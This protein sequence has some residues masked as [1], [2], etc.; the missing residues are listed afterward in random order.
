MKTLEEVCAAIKELK[1]HEMKRFAA[2]LYEMT[3]SEDGKQIWDLSNQKEWCDLLY[4]A[5]ENITEG[6]DL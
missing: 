1:Y 4:Y 6:C 5:A 3:Q 2:Q